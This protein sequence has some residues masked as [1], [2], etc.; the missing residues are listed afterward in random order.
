MALEADLKEVINVNNL[1]KTFRTPFRRKRV[2]AVKSVSFSVEQGEV[3]GFLGPN[4]AGKTTTI[5]MLTGLIQPSGGTMS[6]LGGDPA[7]IAIKARVGFLP[8]Q[9]YFYDYLTPVELLNVFGQIFGIPSKER[10][11]RI[12]ELLEK[13]GLSDAKNRTL[14]KFSKGMMQRTGIAQALLND[15]DIVIL[16]EPLSGLDPIGRREVTDLIADLRSSGKT[17][18]FSSHILA[19]IER[20]CDRVVI[21]DKGLIKASGRLSDL[22]ASST[23]EKEILAGNM[24]S[25]DAF[26]NATG[27]LRAEQYGADSIRLFCDDT[28]SDA[29][30]SDII[31]SGG[32][33]LAV[34][35][36][37]MSLE[38]LFL[39]EASSSRTLQTDTDKSTAESSEG[40]TK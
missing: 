5:K 26:Q 1:S 6:V 33:I 28:R 27:V 40:Q 11:R 10:K 35:D 15:P 23:G 31:G 9:P 30:I 14:R 39:R 19:D 4:G 20:L 8:E 18:F 37:R 21:L 3:F 7:S 12:N 29:I 24:A 36:R 13:V 22:L 25:P 2:D 16:D 38:Q 34:T 32:K 17:V